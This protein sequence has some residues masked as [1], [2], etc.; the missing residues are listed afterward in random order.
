MAEVGA[1]LG[2]EGRLSDA[3]GAVDAEEAV[4]GGHGR[5]AEVGDL[6]AA[7]EE[8][9]GRQVD[10]GRLLEARTPLLGRPAPLRQLLFPNRVV[11]ETLAGYVDPGCV[12]LGISSLGSSLAVFVVSS[13]AL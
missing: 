1:H 5:D 11:V 12:A 4:A 10:D 3:G 2:G 13:V 6:G 8:A 7:D 9:G